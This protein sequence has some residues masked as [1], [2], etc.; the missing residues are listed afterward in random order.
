M[1]V[2]VEVMVKWRRRVVKYFRLTRLV[3]GL[4]FGL[5][6]PGELLYSAVHNAV[7]RKDNYDMPAM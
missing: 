3:V 1:A 5:A 6:L 2:S 7:K 4:V